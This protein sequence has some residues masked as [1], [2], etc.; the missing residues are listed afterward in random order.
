MIVAHKIAL[1]P[2]DVQAT[3]FARACE[4]ARF[5]YNWALGE[6]RRQYKEGG[7]LSEA[8]LRRRLNEVKREQFPW[9]LEVTKVAPQQAIKNLGAAFKKFFAGQGKYPQFKKKG[10]HDNFRSDNGPGTFE[11]K[12]RHIKLPVIGWVRLR[13]P[14]RFAGRPVSATVSRVANRWFVSV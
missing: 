11:V 7:N 8:A 14:L 9:I 3:Y 2:N 13:E 12:D 4:T 6:W 1:D 5:A 10:I